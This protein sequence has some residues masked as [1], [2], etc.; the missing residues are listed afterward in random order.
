[1]IPKPG[2]LSIYSDS[3]CETTKE[4]HKDRPKKLL[5]E[6]SKHTATYP[7]LSYQ[8]SPTCLRN[9]D[10]L[11]DRSILDRTGI[12]MKNSHGLVSLSSHSIEEQETTT[13]EIFGNPR[14][15]LLL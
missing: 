14:A 6:K 11:G 15:K 12:F 1:M 8:L 3:R 13:K 9:L 5:S 7:I 10:D 2:L 4:P